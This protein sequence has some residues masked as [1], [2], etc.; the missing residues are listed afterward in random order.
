ME[1]LVYTSLTL[2]VGFFSKELRMASAKGWLKAH[3]TFYEGAMGGA[4][5]YENVFAEGF[6][7]NTAALSD[8]LFNHGKSCGGCYQIVC[9]ATQVPQW[10]KKGKRITVTATNFCPPNYNLPND[11]G[12]W[13]NPPR[14][15]F[16]MSQPAF[17][18]IAEYKAGIVPIFYRKVMCRRNGGLRFTIN[19]NDYFE[20]VFISN[21]GGYGDI[22]QVWIKGSK[23]KKWEAMSRNWGVNWQS[24]SYLNGQSLSFRVQLANRKIR[25][26]YD[27][28]PSD[29]N[30][31]QTFQTQ[32]QF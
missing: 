12:G 15:H 7:I 23:M 2:L 24:P 29:W 16:D 13:C 27:V 25:T 19:G 14:P 18:T 10:C 20:L 21:V 9:D 22:S 31:G 30:F 1:R 17:E 11:D 6:G 5:G 8:A 32:M 4:C 26:A 28:A 3:A